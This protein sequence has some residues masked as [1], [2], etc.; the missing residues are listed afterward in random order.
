MT[1]AYLLP[2]VVCHTVA[3]H[4]GAGRDGAIAAAN[5]HSP[6][7]LL[8]MVHSSGLRT[9][10]QAAVA[11]GSKWV[12]LATADEDAG[13]RYLIADA[14]DTEPGSFADRALLRQNPLGVIEGIVVAARVLG[15][16]EAFLAIRRSFETEYGIVTRSLAEAETAGW[17]DRVSIKCIRTSDDYL[18]GEPSALLATL[19]GVEA[20][21]LPRDPAFNGL[22]AG[23]ET[24]SRNPTTV[25]SIETLVNVAAVVLNGSA[26]LRGMGTPVSP[27]NLLCT[28]TG[29][30]NR[31]GV[32]EMELGRRLVDA[33][34]EGGCG[35]LPASPPKAVLSGVSS[36]VLT[37]SRLAA[38]MSWEGLAAVGANLGRAAFRVY[39]ESS[40]MFAV[41]HEIAG[42]LYVESCGLCPACKF[43]SGEVTAYLARLVAGVGSRRDLEALGGRLATVTDSAQ[44]ALPTRLREVVSSIMWAF[45]GDAAATVDRTPG[46]VPSVLEPLVDIVDGRAVYG[47]RQSRKRAD[48][49]VQDQPVRLT[50]W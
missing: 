26:W 36:P 38:P 34:E 42:Y 31:H 33:I 17:L 27:G 2:E 48:G 30:V 41:A 28:I 37:R 29:D 18:V 35:F 50:R 13:N 32:V 40:D 25:E 9:R 23:D 24:A 15:V 45:P 49:V 7:R 1:A 5:R 6:R 39:G 8:D 11:L 21:P 4:V 44:C 22:F 20:L 19:E 43:G 47:D 3:E 16:R 46:T 14:T 10:D 12:E